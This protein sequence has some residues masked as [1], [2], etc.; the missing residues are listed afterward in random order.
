MLQLRVTWRESP[1]EWLTSVDAL[2][3]TDKHASSLFVPLHKKV[4]VSS[5]GDG[6]HDCH[7]YPPMLA[8]QVFDFYLGAL[9]WLE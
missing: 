8:R 3:V 5:D 7:Q 6:I 2:F 9:P 1:S 4:M